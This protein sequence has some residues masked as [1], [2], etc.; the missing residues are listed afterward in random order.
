MTNS[1][2]GFQL[3]PEILRAIAAVYGWDGYDAPPV[4]RAA[5]S[6]ENLARFAGRYRSARTRS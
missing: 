4:R 6:P 3:M 1:D 2:A 5:L